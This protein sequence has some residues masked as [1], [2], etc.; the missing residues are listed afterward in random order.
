M[1]L[2]VTDIAT[3]Y[4]PAELIS[5]SDAAGGTMV[6]MTAKIKVHDVDGSLTQNQ[7]LSLSNGKVSLLWDGYEVNMN[8]DGI[9]LGAFEAT[10]LRQGGV[11]SSEYSRQ[12]NEWANPFDPNSEYSRHVFQEEVIN[13]TI[14]RIVTADGA[15]MTR[16]RR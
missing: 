9:D 12:I 7:L 10:V 11:W 13:P 16:L 5:E 1:M 15:I 14:E 2:R 4:G 6:T 3:P 8:L